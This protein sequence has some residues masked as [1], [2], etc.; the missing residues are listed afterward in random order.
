MGYSINI[1]Q[2]RAA[3]RLKCNRNFSESLLQI[4]R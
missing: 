1:S 4:F 3:T 2:G